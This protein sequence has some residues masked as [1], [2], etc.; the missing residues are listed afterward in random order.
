MRWGGLGGGKS[1]AIFSFDFHSRG[2]QGRKTKT[3][4]RRRF[5]ERFK[6]SR[7][8]NGGD[9]S[10]RARF[11]VAPSFR[12][13][14]LRGSSSQTCVVAPRRK[15]ERDGI[16]AS[17]ENARRPAASG[18]HNGTVRN[19]RTTKLFLFMLQERRLDGWIPTKK[20]ERTIA[21]NQQR[22][23]ERGALRDRAQK[24]HARI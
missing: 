18:H 24:L 4:R 15:A 21:T 13:V 14:Y 22:E 1:K 8:G 11:D 23:G 16:D 9:S 12:Y 10:P 6:R 17:A 7:G 19:Q 3:Q 5:L 20:G 2:S